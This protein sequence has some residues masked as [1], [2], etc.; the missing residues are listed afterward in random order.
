MKNISINCLFVI[1]IFALFIIVVWNSNDCILNSFI[2][3]RQCSFISTFNHAIHTSLKIKEKYIILLSIPILSPTF[4][5]SLSI[6]YLPVLAVKYQH[7]PLILRTV[8]IVPLI[9]ILQ[10]I[11]RIL[12]NDTLRTPKS[13]LNRNLL[14]VYVPNQ[15]L[16]LL[17]V[18]CLKN[19]CT[20]YD[21]RAIRALIVRL[22]V[23]PA[24]NEHLVEC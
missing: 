2:Y 23:V 20:F 19:K 15:I 18:V 21:V 3:C 11:N 1:L 9:Y 13:L 5:P 8:S 4:A 7:I 16:S 17:L 12:I 14:R 10:R 24:E 6:R 22:L